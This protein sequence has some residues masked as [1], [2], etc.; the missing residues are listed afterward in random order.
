MIYCCLPLVLFSIR[1]HLLYSGK[2]LT[3]RRISP[4]PGQRIGW[5][6][7]PTS[8][9]LFHKIIGS[10]LN[11][12]QFLLVIQFNSGNCEV[13]TLFMMNSNKITYPV[14]SSEGKNHAHIGGKSP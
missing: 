9:S 1:Q 2:Y 6:D 12:L 5:A 4:H 10:W 8:Y 11:P 13:Q 7:D 14:D 3:S